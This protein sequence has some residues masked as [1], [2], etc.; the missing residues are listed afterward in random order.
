MTAFTPLPQ[1]VELLVHAVVD[2]E[3]IVAITDKRGIIAYA[4]D[5]FCGI[6]GYSRN[7]LLGEN[8]RLLKSGVHP[9]EF[10]RHLWATVLNGRTWRGE[11]CNRAKDGHLYWVETVIAPLRDEGLITHFIAL[12]TDIT[13]RKEAEAALAE[14]GRREEEERRMTT[15]GRLAGG[16]LHDLNNVLTGIMGLVAEDNTEE[17]HIMLQEAIGRMAQITRMLRDY[18]TG[19]PSAPSRFR[20]N[21]MLACAC[22]LVRYRPGAPRNLELIEEVAATEGCIV[23]GNEAQIFEV[24][25]NLAVN[26]VEAAARQSQPMLRLES[27]MTGGMATVIF[28]DNGSGVPAAIVPTLFDPYA[29]TKGRGRGLGLSISRQIVAAHG[30]SLSLER[31]GGDGVGARFQLDLPAEFAPVAPRRLHRPEPAGP[32]RC[33]LVSDDDANVRRMIENVTDEIGLTVMYP[34]DPADLLALASKMKEVLAAAII[35]SCNVGAKQGTVACLRQLKPDL[36]ILLI[37]ANLTARGRQSSPWGDVENLP[38]PF[39]ARE[40]AA[41]LGGL[42]APHARSVS[43]N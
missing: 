12:R 15:L 5:R 40:L 37:S 42:A 17:R 2:H 19:R 38:K 8:H 25:L 1:R 32:R 16:V 29:S 41:V 34:G 24:V 28:E 11:I 22:S 23:T 26:A 7:E 30:G 43:I 39:D 13:A 4:N 10:Y 6:S 27:R 18:S 20:L 31:A 21:P 33:V 9:P 3:A 14:Q 35:D 36:P